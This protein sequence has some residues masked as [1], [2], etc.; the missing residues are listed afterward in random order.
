VKT[1]VD[2]NV[3]VALFSGD[4]DASAATQAALEEA[5]A[6]GPLG[7][8]PAVYAELVAGRDEAFVERFLSEKDIEVDWDQNREVWSTAGVRYGQYA[9]ARRKQNGD[10]G[11]RRI[12]AD[13]LIGAHALRL[14]GAL[15]T[16]DARIYGT[17]FPEL[18]V[19]TPEGATG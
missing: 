5:R 1:A 19:L 17:Y 10:P 2:T 16:S 7:I 14:A 18:K 12:L 15:L 4:A 13:F 9:Q 6:G 8:A 11:P 3:F